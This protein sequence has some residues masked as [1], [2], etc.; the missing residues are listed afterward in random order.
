MNDLLFSSAFN[1]STL[2][3]VCAP[4]CYRAASHSPAEVDTLVICEE[5]SKVMVF[6]SQPNRSW[7]AATQSSKSGLIVAASL[8]IINCC[9]HLVVPLRNP[10]S[11]CPL[12]MGSTCICQVRKFVPSSLIAQG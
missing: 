8:S 1:I 9:G 5:I 11:L 12:I 6:N 2:A 4:A 10:S 3:L 7:S